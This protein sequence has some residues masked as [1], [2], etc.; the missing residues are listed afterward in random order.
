MT[1]MSNPAHDPGADGVEPDATPGKRPLHPAHPA[2]KAPDILLGNQSVSRE[3]PLFG[4]GLMTPP[5]CR[6]EGL[7]A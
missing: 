4:A 7:Q 6:T 3:D 5:E 1:S 2:T